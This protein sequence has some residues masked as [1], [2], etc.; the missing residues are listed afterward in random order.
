MTDPRDF[1]G[2]IR[3]PMPT[4]TRAQ[5]ARQALSAIASK[6]ASGR[7]ATI[8]ISGPKL[9]AV[10]RAKALTQRDLAVLTAE[11]GTAVSVET[12]ERIEQSGETLALRPTVEAL[13]AALDLLAGTLAKS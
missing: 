2:I 12:I 8:P 13:E 10:R 5:V 1:P 6:P 7:A 11:A 4:P 3:R 9:K